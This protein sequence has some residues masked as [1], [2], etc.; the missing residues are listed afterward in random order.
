MFQFKSGHVIIV[1]NMILRTSKKVDLEFLMLPGI[2]FL[3]KDFTKF[4]FPEFL[5]AEINSLQAFFQ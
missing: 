1:T 3:F 4:H 5:L 2:K